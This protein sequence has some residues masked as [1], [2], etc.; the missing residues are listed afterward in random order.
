MFK[1]VKSRSEKRRQT[2][3]RTFRLQK[4]W[5]DV[6]EEDAEKQGIS[7]N[8]LVNKI[9][10]RYA[11]FTRW[12]D[13]MGLQSFSP[14]TFKGILEEIP[15][16]SLARTGAK[17]GASDFLDILNMMG[18]PLNFESFTDLVLEHFGGSDSCRWYTCFHHAQGNQHI[19]HI[20]HNL[21]RIWSIYLKEYLLSGLNSLTKFNSD[22]KIYDSAVNLKVATP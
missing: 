7:V 1:Q 21:G 13:Y 9:L 17:F 6:L 15:A 12:A 5:D 10:R 20:Q 4:E 22:V 8:V 18:K 16:E 14:Q 11:L 2:V 3:T 19:F